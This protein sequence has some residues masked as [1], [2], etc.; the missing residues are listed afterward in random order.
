MPSY[1]SGDCTRRR[2]GHDAQKNL[3]GEE[4]PAPLALPW[5]E[6]SDRLAAEVVFDLPI[7][8]TFHYLVPDELR[9]LIEPGQRVRAPFGRG[10][11]PTVGYCVALG[12]PP[13]IRH[14]LKE[15]SDILDQE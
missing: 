4:E 6:V 12:P 10:N 8:T 2:M 7:E 11:K 14:R 15:L 3:F 5:E 9:E 1:I 13:N